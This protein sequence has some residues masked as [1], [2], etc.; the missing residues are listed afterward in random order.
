MID[1]LPLPGQQRMDAA[2]AE[3]A[4]LLRQ[5]DNACAQGSRF[6]ALPARIANMLRL[7]LTNSQ[8]RRSD[9][10]SQYA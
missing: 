6:G 7:I 2:I 5:Y 4:P 8:A 9:I 1:R 10:R 3:T